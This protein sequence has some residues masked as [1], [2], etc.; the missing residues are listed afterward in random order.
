[1]D[2]NFKLSVKVSVLPL[3]FLHKMEVVPTNDNGPHHL[4]TVAG[5]RKNTASNGDIAGE[6]AL[7][8][9]VSS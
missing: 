2:F 1:M 5:T 7:L 9:N 3:V 6:W 8:V 4:R